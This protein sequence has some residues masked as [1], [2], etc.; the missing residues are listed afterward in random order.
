MPL[1]QTGFFSRF[2]HKSTVR[3]INDQ[4]IVFS[5]KRKEIPRLN[6]TLEPLGRSC[7]HNINKVYYR[8]LQHN[9]I[10]RRKSIRIFTDATETTR[11]APKPACSPML[12]NTPWRFSSEEIVMA[13]LWYSASNRSWIMDRNL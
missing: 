6:M 7:V 9:P 2:Y 10:R 12:F 5:T 13:F 8:T 11:K 4:T 3:K 1:H